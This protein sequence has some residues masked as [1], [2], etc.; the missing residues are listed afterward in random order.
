MVA[1]ATMNAT[2]I[3]KSRLNTRDDYLYN[4]ELAR[5]I[6]VSTCDDEA[7][8]DAQGHSTQNVFQMFEVVS[9]TCPS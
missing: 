4:Q 6:R 9:V 5:I 7:K 1:K 2:N 3:A 8:K